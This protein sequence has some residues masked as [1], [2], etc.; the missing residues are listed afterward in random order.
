MLDKESFTI[1]RCRNEMKLIREYS[2]ISAYDWVSDN[3][4]VRI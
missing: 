3:I 1:G 4:H 2:G